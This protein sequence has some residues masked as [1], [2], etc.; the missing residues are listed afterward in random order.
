MGPQNR[1]QGAEPVDRYDQ[2]EPTRIGSAQQLDGEHVVDD[3]DRHPGSLSHTPGL[4]T[5]SPLATLIDKSRPWAG[6]DEC[7]TGR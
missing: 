7:P 1:A 3:G 6:Q 2:F 4:A 5:R